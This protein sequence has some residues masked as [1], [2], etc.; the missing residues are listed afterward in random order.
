MQVL[1]CPVGIYLFCDILHSVTNNQVQD[2]LIH[3]CDFCHGDERMPGIM[4]FMLHVQSVHYF[5]E[6]S[7]VFVV[8]QEYTLLAVRIVEKVITV[9][10]LGLIIIFLYKLPDPWVDWDNP[11]FPGIC[12]QTSCDG[13]MVQINIINLQYG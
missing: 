6:P 1:N 11:I 5:V 2:V 7:L 8:I 4:W 10:F 9:H 3:I 13:S 12:F